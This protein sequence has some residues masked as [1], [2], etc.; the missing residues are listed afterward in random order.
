MSIAGRKMENIRRSSPSPQGKRGVGVSRTMGEGAAAG[1]GEARPTAGAGT[2][3]KPPGRRSRGGAGTRSF[4]SGASGTIDAFSATSANLNVAP[5]TAVA[6]GEVSASAGSV[7]ALAA[8]ISCG[9]ARGGTTSYLG[10][11]PIVAPGSH[12]EEESPRGLKTL[13]GCSSP[14]IYNP[15]CCN[16]TSPRNSP[17]HIVNWLCGYLSLEQIGSKNINIYMYI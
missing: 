2:V 17:T 6:I 8:A 12:V 9:S 1:K 3:T 5:I 11:L 13:G 10:L 16:N 14:F 7:G 4:F 15:G